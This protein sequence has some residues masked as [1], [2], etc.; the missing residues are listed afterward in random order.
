MTD[1]H[2]NRPQRG[3]DDWDEPTN[4]N[5]ADLGV[6][7]AN[8]VA[9]WSDLPATSEVTQSSDG[10]WPVYRVEADDIFVRVTDS[11]TEIVGGLGSADH[12]L[13]ES[14]HEAINAE[15]TRTEELGFTRN[16]YPTYPRG[17]DAPGNYALQPAA[18]VDNPIVDDTTDSSIDGGADPFIVW[19]SPY[20]YIFF[21]TFNSDGGRDI[22]VVR[23]ANLQ[24]WT[25][26]G[27][28]LAES[29]DQGYPFLQKLDGTWYLIPTNTTQN[30]KV[31]IY[32]AD[33]FPLSWT[34]RETALDAA[35]FGVSE[36]VDPTPFYHPESEK[37][38][39]MAMDSDD[40]NYLYYSDTLL[41]GDWSPH[42]DN[43]V[44][45]APA[46]MRGTPI[47]GD[48]YVDLMAKPTVT[49]ARITELSPT[50]YADTDL[51][52]ILDAEENGHWNSDNMHHVDALTTRHGANVVAVDGWNDA[53]SKYHIGL[54]SW[55]DQP[56]SA[57]R[58]YQP[59]SVIQSV[60]SASY[61]EVALESVSHSVPSI[62]V[63]T[64]SYQITANQSGYYTVSGQVTFE[65]ATG[66]PFRAY[67]RISNRDTGDNVVVASVQPALDDSFSVQLSQ[68]TVYLERGD[69]IFLEAWQDSGNDLLVQDGEG[70]TFLQVERAW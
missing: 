69:S 16:K 33:S 68:T 41:D 39:L 20:Y 6:E 56:F 43:P 17:P 54:Y 58:L 9:T 40:A 32:E 64:S 12:K 25:W 35:N 55:A 62:N 65:E 60:P 47:V 4:E 30:D 34:R 66:A 26:Q 14:H 63:S 28:A 2:Y 52:Q 19:D 29:F 23:S 24:D 57:G 37:W 11:A 31:Y 5:F 15:D 13:P 10:Q 38:Y 61:T 70:A 8:E 18:F 46:K 50:A 27:R 51:G 44:R 3:A 53:E 22:G 48:G 42:P 67:A 21:E 49:V 7:V 1:D 59:S 36:F 45:E